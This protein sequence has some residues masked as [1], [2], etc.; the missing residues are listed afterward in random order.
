M[1]GISSIVIGVVAW[2]LVADSIM[3]ARQD[4]RKL[5][6]VRGLPVQGHDIVAG[7]D[8]FGTQHI[9]YPRLRERLRA[10]GADLFLGRPL[11]S[12]MLCRFKEVLCDV[13]REKGFPV[14][15]VTHDTRP[16][17]GNPRHLTLMFTI[18]EGKRSRGAVHD[19]RWTTNSSGGGI[20]ARRALQAYRLADV[21]T[22]M[23]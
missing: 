15:E 22:E 8:I 6:G 20:A 10:N 12:Q 21:S 18:S 11:E 16:T 9:D 7:I 19:E 17:Y 23:V 13:M 4:D 5:A 3:F 1:K 2:M 14:A